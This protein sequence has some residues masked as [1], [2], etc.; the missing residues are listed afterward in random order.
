MKQRGRM[1]RRRDGATHPTTPPPRSKPPG[2]C[3]PLEL[4]DVSDPSF[5]RA[6][7]VRI[8]WREPLDEGDDVIW[9]YELQ[10]GRSL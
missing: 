6:H 9:K 8:V 5:D 2:K 7:S 3:P 1:P 4:G 10:V